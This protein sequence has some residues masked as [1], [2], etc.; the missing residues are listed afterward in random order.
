MRGRERCGCGFSRRSRC[1]QREESRPGGDGRTRRTTPEPARSQGANVLWPPRR[2]ECDVSI[3]I[4][5][6]GP[7][8]GLPSRLSL[9]APAREAHAR[10]GRG[11]HR[12]AR[13]HAPCVILPDS[14]G[15]RRQSSPAPPARAAPR[16]DARRRRRTRHAQAAVAHR[17]RPRST[18]S[19]SR[20]PPRPA[21]WPQART[22]SRMHPPRPRRRRPLRP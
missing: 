2:G 4:E 3:D 1:A 14:P 17:H 5:A 16:G 19:L 9:G 10:C 6:D 7:A 21:G 15:A 11:R 13:P 18:R 8:P 22:D 12:A 20:R